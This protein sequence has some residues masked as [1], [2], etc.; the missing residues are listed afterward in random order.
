MDGYVTC[1]VQSSL[2]RKQVTIHRMIAL[3]FIPNSDPEKIQ[4]NH[5]DGNKTNNNILNLEW[6]TPSENMQHAVGTGLLIPVTGLGHGLSK[7][8]L[9]HLED[10]TIIKMYDSIKNCSEETG[11]NIQFAR[12]RITSGKPINSDNH[13]LTILVKKIHQFNL[14]N[15]FIK[16]HDSIADAI[17]SIGR[18]NPSTISASLNGHRKAA[19]G[20]I[21]KWV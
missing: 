20:F 13:Y 2:N 11:L 4:V 6:C 1:T 5:I 3:A 9:H 10:G 14:D 7:Q 12:R 16:E 17:S 19:H 18:T 21:W 8:V 15:S